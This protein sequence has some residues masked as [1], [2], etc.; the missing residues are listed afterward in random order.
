MK[1]LYKIGLIMFV[2]I[3]LSAFFVMAKPTEDE[4]K[5]ILVKSL[6]GSKDFNLTDDISKE[7]LKEQ[8]KIIKIEALKEDKLSIVDVEVNNKSMKFITTSIL[9]KLIYQPAQALENIRE[10]FTVTKTLFYNRLKA[11]SYHF[12]ESDSPNPICTKANNNRYVGCI[13]TVNSKVWNPEILDYEY[14]Y[15]WDCEEKP[16]CTRISAEIEAEKYLADSNITEKE[17]LLADVRANIT[18]L[19]SYGEI[20]GLAGNITGTD[21]RNTVDVNVSDIGSGENIGDI[22]DEDIGITKVNGSVI[23]KL[24]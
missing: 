16:E 24:G 7:Q 21:L 17:I 1:Y 20:F 19:E 2:V 15:S 11:T 8:I 23:I 22:P 3:V 5:E 12:L 13:P 14:A 4:V 18:S 9:S 10:F 6:N